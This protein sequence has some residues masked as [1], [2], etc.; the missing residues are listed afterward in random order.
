ME[1]FK[2]Q[3]DDKSISIHDPGGLP[4]SLIPK[5]QITM[6]GKYKYNAHPHQYSTLD[7]SY[8]N[9]LTTSLLDTYFFASLMHME[10]HHC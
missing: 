5:V 8:Q 2:T 6:Q 7:Q 3:A 9:Y 4:F 10:K 1:V